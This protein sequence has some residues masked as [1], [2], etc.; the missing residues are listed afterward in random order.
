ME[1]E[2]ERESSILNL[3]ALARRAGYIF[4][5]NLSGIANSKAD[6]SDGTSVLSE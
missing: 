3:F 1:R 6:R 2:K 4:H 5:K